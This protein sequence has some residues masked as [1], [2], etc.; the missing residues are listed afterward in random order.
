MRLST[1]INTHL[2]ELLGEWVAFAVSHAPEGRRTDYDALRDHADEMLT[3]IAKDLDRPISAR[4]T[5]IEWRGLVD[6]AAPSAEAAALAHG[7]QRAAYGFSPREMVA[8]FRALRATVL[9]GWLMTIDGSTTDHLHEVI[10]FDG[11]VTHTLTASVA[12]Y[13]EEQDHARDLF[14]GILGHDLKT[15]L[16]AIIAA[17]G[18]V[19]EVEELDETGRSMIERIRSVAQRMT[20]MISELLDF[21]RVR[22]GSGIP[23]ARQQTDLG[24]VVRDTIEEAKIAYPRSDVRVRLTGPLE[25]CADPARIHQA[26]SNLITNAV[27]HGAAN[28]PVEAVAHGGEQEITISVH[29][30]G[31]SIPPEQ[32]KQL[33]RPFEGAATHD[34]KSRDPDHLG[35]GLFIANSIVTAHGGRIGVQSSPERGTTFTV[36]IPRDESCGSPKN[37]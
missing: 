3:A 17:A 29:N 9:R 20:R 4:E 34:A 15:P 10:R 35:L 31:S 13:M 8:E 5:Q 37:V 27:Q 28:E 23:L 33:F 11:A 2:D 19:G 32:L 18:V 22:L 7:A 36:Q 12:R 6:E 1:Y 16:S 14:L 26:L 24:M 25:A 30:E 21:T